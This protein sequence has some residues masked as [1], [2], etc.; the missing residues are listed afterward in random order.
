MKPAEGYKWSKQQQGDWSYKHYKRIGTQIIMGTNHS[1]YAVC[2]KSRV[3][4][5]YASY[6]ICNGIAGHSMIHKTLKEAKER[7]DT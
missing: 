6:T 1:V 4:S 3:K 7:F 5:G 2:H